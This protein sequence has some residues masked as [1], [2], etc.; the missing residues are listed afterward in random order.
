MELAPE[1]LKVAKQL[2][3][4]YGEDAVLTEM[5]MNAYDPNNIDPPQINPT[6]D[7]K[8]FI[9]TNKSAKITNRLTLSNN[10]VTEGLELTYDLTVL[11]Y[12]DEAVGEILRSWLFNG[13][14]IV[15]ISKL[16]A[17]GKTVLFEIKVRTA[18]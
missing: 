1:L 15:D 4:Q 16:G 7:I 10:Q 18:K 2:I 14:N 11:I 12:F 3:D 8:A 6:Y 9:D 13:Y 17:E 5:P